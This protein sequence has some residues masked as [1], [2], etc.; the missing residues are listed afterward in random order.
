MGSERCRCA[1]DSGRVKEVELNAHAADA[2]EGTKEAVSN[3]M[4]EHV[5]K[6]VKV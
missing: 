2:S 3:D 6:D 1:L 5:N 4:P